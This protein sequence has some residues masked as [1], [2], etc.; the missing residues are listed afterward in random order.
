[1]STLHDHH[2]AMLTDES[3]IHTDLITAR[4]YK[5]VTVKAEL[6]R[7][8]FSSKQRNVPA[9]LIPIYSPTGVATLYQ[10]RPDEPRI[11]KGKPVKYET[12]SGSSMALDVHPSVNSK[13]DDPSIPLFVTEGIKKGD[14]LAT[15]GLCAVA[16]IGVWNWRG[17]N[18]RGGKVVLPEWEFIALNDRRVYIVFDS[19]VMEKK[20]VHAALV[21]IKGMLE[22]RGA[23][24]KLIYLP[25]GNG[26]VK[27]GVDDYLA[28]GHTVDDLLALATSE[29]KAAPKEEPTSKGRPEIE[30]NG[31]HLREI[32]DDALAALLAANDPPVLFLRGTVPS[33]INGEK[34]EALNGT[35]LKGRLDRVADFVKTTYRD[36]EPVTN[37]ARPPADVPPDILTHTELPFPK[38]KEIVHAPVFLPGGVLLAEDGYDYEHE[39]L[40][41][42]RGLEDLRADLPIAEALAQLEEVYADFP[43]VEQAG[44]AHALAMTLQPFVRPLIQGATP[45]YLIDAPAR[46][47][48]KGLLA[49]VMNLIPLGYVVPTMS[50]PKDTDELE[51]RITSVLLEA[52]PIVFLDNVTRLGSEPLHAVLTSETWQGRPLGKSETATV[53]NRAVWLASGNNVE[54]TDEMTRR[55]A[56]I[57]LDAGVERPE[58]RTGFKHSNL[59]QYVRE[60]RSQLVSACLSLVQAWVDE[61]M[62]KDTG[63]L[64]RYEMWAGIMGGILEVA[65]V[66]GFLG[67]RERLH[68]E[69]DKETTEWAALC[70]AWWSTFEK[71]P[72]AA[73]ELFDILKDRHL[74]LDV[75]G[76]R[77]QQGALQRI[78]HALGSRRDRVFG[79]YKIVSA[80][81]DGVTRSAAYRLVRVGSTTTENPETTSQGAAMPFLMLGN[82]ESSFGGF[83]DEQTQTTDKPQQNHRAEKIVQYGPPPAPSRVSGI[84]VV[85]ER[86]A[87]QEEYEGVESDDLSHLIGTTEGEL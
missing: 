38:L 75:W 52:R 54:L 57:R 78:G 11:N 74:L 13:L 25:S 27:Q 28:S 17:K 79:G 43:F 26:A 8:G 20:A 29:L 33:R 35:S 23:K 18:P 4:S 21:R 51:K 70:D 81:R 63:T 72:I 34:I 44:R 73:R 42:L 58:E 9:L 1:L 84:S 86:P 71:R 19:D 65:G 12:P 53:P 7:L 24:V 48:G 49:E 5:T 60:N 40:L 14:A 76:G 64:G 69:A 66:P 37:P 36:G 45:M 6:E 3:G 39:L 62:P 50:Q 87:S 80:G 15:H 56:P 46:G 2:R 41:K 61:G 85:L 59:P 31:R 47:T 55:I 32:T 83:G 22:H 77:T 82:D 10:T 67:G 68:G 16:L 30:V